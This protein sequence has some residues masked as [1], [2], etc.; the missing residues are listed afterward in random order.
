[1]AERGDQTF[2]Y[3]QEMWRHL[4]DYKVS[5]LGVRKNG[6]WRKNRREYAHILPSQLQRLNILEPYRDQFWAYFGKVQFKLHSDFHHL[7]S[8]QAMCFNLFFPFLAEEKYLQL[9]T[10]IFTSDG[11]IE[12]AGFEAVLDAS[13]GTNFDFC[14]K[15]E[16]SKTLF[17]IKLT[18]SDF[19]KAKSDD[20][21]RSKFEIVY[22]PALTGKFAPSFSTCDV[23]L[24]H[25]QLM[26]NVWNLG[27][28]TGDRLVC[29]VP[30]AN[31]NLSKEIKFLENCL[32]VPYRQ[33]VSIHYLEDVAATVEKTIP[34]DAIR[35]KEHFRMFRRKYLPDFEEAR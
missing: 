9:L 17:E 1:M 23:F 34:D 18:E 27:V 11:V 19:G 4:A 26:R 32:S 5:S 21:H 3:K 8:S 33:R 22:S 13:E 30:K 20:S 31:R 14:Y 25:Y 24:E 29:I 16:E 28:G 15:T 35:M 7:S 12:G 6:I 2:S 10:H